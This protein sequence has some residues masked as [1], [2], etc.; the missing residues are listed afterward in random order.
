[1]SFLDI[2]SKSKSKYIIGVDE[3]GRGCFMGPMVVGF[4]L[5]HPDLEQL[6]SLND[7]KKLTDK[8][9]RQLAPQ[10]ARLT[11]FLMVRIP[12]EFIDLHG[13]NMGYLY[14]CKQFVRYFELNLDECEFLLDYGIKTPREFVGQSFKKGDSKCYSIASASILA[15]VYRDSYMQNLQLVLPEFDPASHKGYGTLKHR[16][17]LS[18]T[19]PSYEHRLSFIKS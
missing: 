19:A 6:E 4:C 18:T 13:L 17:I 2:E 14:A 1:M 5:Y 12:A 7:S 9:R 8:V 16:A 15:K 10:I 11:R 3:V